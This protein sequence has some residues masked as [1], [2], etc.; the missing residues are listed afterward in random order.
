MESFFFDRSSNV[1]RAAAAL[2]WAFYAEN[3][4]LNHQD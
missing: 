1:I 2:E 3:M 4:N